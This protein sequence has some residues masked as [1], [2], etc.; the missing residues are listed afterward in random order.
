LTPS[1]AWQTDDRVFVL[2]VIENSWQFMRDNWLSNKIFTG[3]DDIVRHC[4][5]YSNRLIEQPWR[6]MSIGLRDW[7]HRF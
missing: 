1:V 2:N 3:D 5:F 6:I 4:C 7:T